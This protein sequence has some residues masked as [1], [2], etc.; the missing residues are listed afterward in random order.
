MMRGWL[1]VDELT[2]SDG[3]DWFHFNQDGGVLDRA[4]DWKTFEAMFAQDV[5]FITGT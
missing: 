4:T 5:D 3:Q 1:T 2:G